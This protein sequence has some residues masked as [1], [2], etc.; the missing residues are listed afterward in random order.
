M[1]VHI[2]TPLY[3]LLLYSY[4]AKQG[5]VYNFHM[6]ACI[7]IHIHVCMFVFYTLK[8]DSRKHCHACL[9]LSWEADCVIDLNIVC[10]LTSSI[11]KT[12]EYII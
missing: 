4:V 10:L 1:Y 7:F 3:I 12:I 6:K 8:N 11:C 9:Q 5:L 2:Y